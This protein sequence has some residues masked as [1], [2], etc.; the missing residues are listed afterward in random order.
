MTIKWNLGHLYNFDRQ[1]R[2][3]SLCL[4]RPFRHSLKSIRTRFFAIHRFRWLF[5]VCGFAC[6]ISF[7]TKS[8]TIKTGLAARLS[9]LTFSS[10]YLWTLIDREPDRDLVWELCDLFSWEVCWLSSTVR[11]LLKMGVYVYPRQEMTFNGSS[12]RQ[13]SLGMTNHCPAVEK[14]IPHREYGL[15][16]LFSSNEV[17]LEWVKAGDKLSH[18]R[19]TLFRAS[20]LTRRHA[21]FDLI[22]SR[23]ILNGWKIRLGQQFSKHGTIR[24]G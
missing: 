8:P 7:P 14:C 2:I 19:Q 20:R 18:V 12:S 15:E 11:S 24:C 22:N 9:C 5:S 6:V 23:F 3:P 16:S 17:A 4:L 13:S 1:G 10:L 21:S